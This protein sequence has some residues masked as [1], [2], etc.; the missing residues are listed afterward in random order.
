M[1]ESYSSKLSRVYEKGKTSTRVSGSLGLE[2]IFLIENLKGNEHLIVD[3]TL[4]N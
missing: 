4:E 3:G 2:R 1:S